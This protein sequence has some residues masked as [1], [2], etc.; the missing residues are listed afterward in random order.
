MY[1]SPFITAAK[2]TS[3]DV[4]GL[5]RGLVSGDVGASRNPVAHTEGSNITTSNH[6]T[7]NGHQNIGRNG[8][9]VCELDVAALSPILDRKALNVDVPRTFSRSIHIH[10][11]D[12]SLVILVKQCWQVLGDLGGKHSGYEFTLGARGWN[13]WL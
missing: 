1:C 5:I 4:G 3:G 8:E 11:I 7:R 12:G 6:G 9:R 13:S 10:H 2:V